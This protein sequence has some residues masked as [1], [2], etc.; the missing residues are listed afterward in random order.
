MSMEQRIEAPKKSVDTGLQSLVVCA[1]FFGIPADAEQLRRAYVGTGRMDALTLVRAARDLSLKAKL[2]SFARERFLRMPLPAVFSLQNGDFIVILRR[3]GDKAVVIDPQLPQPVVVEISRLLPALGSNVILMTRRFQLQKAM[4]K[5]GLAWFA[6][7]AWKYK[8][9]FGQVLLVSLFLQ[10]FGLVTPLFTQ[11]IIDKVLVHRSALTLDVLV[12]AMF[13]VGMFQVWFSSLRSYVFTHTTNKLDVVL[14][15]QV[16][17]H[18]TSL[19]MR[20]F[21]TWQVG[22]VVS[23]V[24]ELENI[25]QFITGS[26]LTIVLDV[27]FAVVCIVVM[28][29]YSG[30]LSVVALAALPIFIILNVVVAPIFR[31]LLNERFQAGAE[32]QSFLIEAVT[33]MQTVKAMAVE[34]QL[35]QR[36]EGIL[37]RFVKAAFATSNVANFASSIGTFIQQFFNLAILWVGASAVLNGTLTVGELIAFQMIAGQVTGPILRLVN[38]W[39]YFQQ[40]MVSVERV[41]DIMNEGAEPAFNPNRTTLPSLTGEVLLDR[42][43]FRYRADGNEVLSQVSMHVRPGQRI[44]IVGRSGSG[45]STLTKLL[46]RL[47]V[48]ESGRV[49]IDGVDLAQVEPAW[50]RRQI[51][52]V[53]QENVLFAGSVRDNIAIANAMAT[54]EE[55]EEA[56]KLA[57]AHE[58]IQELPHGYQTQVGERGGLLSGGQRQ[59]LAIARAVL[60]NPRILIFDEATSALDYETERIIMDNLDRLATGRTMFLIAHRLSTVR[61]CDQIIV[62][63]HGRIVEV[64]THTELISSNGYYAGLYHQQAG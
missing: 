51:G 3:E 23:R 42:V 53:L 12:F 26:A 41:G 15:S 64:G 2:T 44:G 6:P 52:V 14:S 60:N 1:R 29:M 34:K 48:P 39:Q 40:T 47:Y 36:Y 50:L 61:N 43:T 17:R 10:M 56:A 24:R 27:I 7:I 8:R 25:R 19:P 38:M 4:G 45:K 58:F 31:R 63:D 32:N 16:F 35:V 37:A 11:V 9:Q 46:Q 18:I 21:E 30:T 13:V 59:R 20:Y 5:F 57:G 62:M 55:I 49:L 33:G 22:D 54:Q 28:L